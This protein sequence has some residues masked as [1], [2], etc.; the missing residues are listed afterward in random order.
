VDFLG[1]RFICRKDG[2]KR[3]IKPRK[4]QAL[5]DAVREQTPRLSGKSTPTLVKTL[6][7][8]L[9]GVFEYFKH[10]SPKPQP[11]RVNM[12]ALLDSCVGFRLRR[13]LAKRQKRLFSGRSLGA[14]KRWTNKFFVKLG[15][16][17]MQTALANSHSRG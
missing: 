11:N 6:N 3:E 2:L 1:Y 9:R 7:L 12:L 16:F 5:K 15:L 10:I 14:H 13:I 4:F 8:F 17:S